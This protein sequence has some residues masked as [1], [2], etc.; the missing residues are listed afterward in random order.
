MSIHKEGVKSLIVVFLT[1]IVICFSL[2]LAFGN[3]TLYFSSFVST[4]FFLFV[5]RFFREPKRIIN[6]NNE[7]LL[8]PAD[9]TIVAIEEVYESEYLKTKCIQISIFMSVWNVHINWYPIKGRVE[10]F[11]YHPGKYLVAWHPKSSTLN[12]RTSIALMR[13]DGITILFRQIAGYLARRVV[14]YAMENHL[15]EQGQQV[16]FIKLGSRVD[17]F[18]PLDSVVKVELNQKVV[19]TQTVIALVPNQKNK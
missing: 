6:Y 3:I 11:R 4:L 9:G 8:S 17:I 10:F 12:E 14:C 1:L 16:G 18:I 15:V 2:W 13:D 19:G 7:H 5:L